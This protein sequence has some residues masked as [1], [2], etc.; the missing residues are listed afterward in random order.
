M[1]AIILIAST[2]SIICGL[3]ILEYAAP[4]YVQANI[5]YCDQQY[6]STKNI[7]T[8]YNVDNSQNINDAMDCQGKVWSEHE[9]IKKQGFW[10]TGIGVITGIA[11]LAAISFSRKSQSPPVA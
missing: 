9:S 1:K 10:F 8:F 11:S 6:D 4:D 5:G 2:L 7:N 3:W